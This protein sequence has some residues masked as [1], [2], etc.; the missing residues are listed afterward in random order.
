MLNKRFLIGLIGLL[1]L[2]GC[3]GVG[4]VASSDPNTKLNDAEYL[5]KSYNRPLIAERLIREAIVIYQERDDP[6][7]LGKAYREYGDLLRSESITGNWQKYYRENGFQDQSVT[8]DNRIAKSTEYY[9]KA[10]EYF[11]RVEKQLRATGPFDTLTNVY[12]NM[13]Y[14]S[15]MLDDKIKACR[16]YDLTIEAYAENIKRNP[17]VKPYSPP[18][19]TLPELVETHKRSIGCA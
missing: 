17:G 3:A 16:Y 11:A 6:H 8:F 14:I 4:V 19:T 9:A 5:F 15:I 1:F 12:Y 13:A 18:G 2:Y 7:G 10:L